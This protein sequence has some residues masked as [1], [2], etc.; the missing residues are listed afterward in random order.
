MS[1]T[2]EQ[3]LAQ[4][5]GDGRG[6]EVTLPSGLTY[7]L[8]QADI[9]SLVDEDGHVPNLLRGVVNGERQEAQSEDEARDMLAQMTD[10][11]PFLNRVTRACLVCPA[12]VDDE[13]MARGEGITLAQVPLMD[14]VA[15]IS[16]AM[17][18]EQALQAVRFPSAETA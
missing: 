2:T 15:L 10:A 6:D 12:I 8:V 17:G 13:G 11:A 3:I 18:G 14:K 5:L 4:F 7:R 16:Y 9:L 1:M